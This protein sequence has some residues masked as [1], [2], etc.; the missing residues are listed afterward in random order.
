MGNNVYKMDSNENLAV[1]K[2]VVDL[3]RFNLIYGTPNLEL[4]IS[5]YEF[6]KLQEQTAFV[7]EIGF[8]NM[9]L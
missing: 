1:M 8:W 5:R 3:I 2:V 6:L 7:L 4:W 9:I